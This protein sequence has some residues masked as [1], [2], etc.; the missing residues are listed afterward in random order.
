MHFKIRQKVRK[1]VVFFQIINGHGLFWPRGG[2]ANAI[3]YL[4]KNYKYYCRNSIGIDII[5]GF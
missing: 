3:F 5:R 4:V 1:N 2:Y